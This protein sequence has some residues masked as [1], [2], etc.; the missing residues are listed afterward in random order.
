MPRQLPQNDITES[1]ETLCE[2]AAV[3]GGAAAGSSGL[4]QIL[5]S[6]SLNQLWG[7]INPLQILIHT[8]LFDVN[9]PSNAS[10]VTK[11]II[12]VATFDIPYIEV[13]TLFKSFAKLPKDDKPE[14]F[15]D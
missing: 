13:D 14:I 12:L 3:L 2:T 8:R 7:M 1:V 11:N 5:I 10:L 4:I 6:G 15:T 9:F